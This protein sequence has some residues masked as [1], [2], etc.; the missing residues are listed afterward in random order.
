MQGSARSS[1][2]G[3]RVWRW[4]VPCPVRHRV[5][6]RGTSPGEISIPD[7]HAEGRHHPHDAQETPG[8]AALTLAVLVVGLLPR[9]WLASILTL[10]KDEA[11]YWAWSLR[12]DESYALVPVGAIRL[13]CA[14]LGATEWAVRLP[15]LLA[16]TGAAACVY[17]LARAAGYSASTARVS[18]ALFSANTWFL[19]AG[20]QAHPDAFVALFWTGA[21][22]SLVRSEASGT[23]HAGRWVCAGAVLA[24]LAALSKYTGFL[25][26]PA[27]VLARAVAERSQPTRLR[28]FAVPSLLWLAVVAPT[29]LTLA[30]QRGHMLHVALGLSDLGDCVPPFARPVAYLLAPLLLLFSPVY[31]IY[32]A[33]FA[34]STGTHS[35]ARRSLRLVGVLTASVIGAFAMWGNIKGNWPLPA[36]WGTIPVG[37]AWAV[38][39][40]WRR[41]SLAATLFVGT[42]IAVAVALGVADPD[43]ASRLVDSCVFF[44]RINSTYSDTISPYESRHTRARSWLDRA[45]ESYGAQEMTDSLAARA[46][47]CGAG[48]VVVSNL[49]EVVYECRF[50]GRMDNARIVDDARFQMTPEYLGRDQEAPPRALYVGLPGSSPS[51]EV[52]RKYSALRLLGTLS[53]P[54]GS[55]GARRYDLW[56]GE[57]AQ[58]GGTGAALPPRSRRTVT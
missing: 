19:L 25:L 35:D 6:R 26:W 9:C 40:P 52:R 7:A 43:A 32:L 50:Y 28:R 46:S 56:C 58:V 54:V 24:A 44:S 53:V 23:R 33:G 15:F 22:A 20:S 16:M 36:L 49:Y 13:S 42:A 1:G 51:D 5:R 37:A 38:K 31:G 12:L 48:T 27:W 29:L 3:A 14:L 17:A 45:Y 41:A 34:A 21:L 18:L 10:S 47:S 30:A 39:G 57:R 8:H 4:K 11:L 2:K 55:R